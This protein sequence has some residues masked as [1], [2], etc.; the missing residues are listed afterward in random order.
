MK[1]S[2]KVVKSSMP[3]FEEYAEEIRELWDTHW[4]TNNGS[5]H[6]ELEVKMKEFLDV[7]NL[8]L[9][10]NG[11]L[12]LELLINMMDLSG[13][14]IT[15]A[16]TFPSTTH[17]IVRNGLTPVFC[18]I[19]RYDMTIDADKIEELITEKTSAIL[20]VHI[21]GNPCDVEKI[22]KIAEKHNLKVIYDAAQSF[23]VKVG[24]KGIG[25]FG[26]ASM[27]SLHATKSFHT[28]EGGAVTF[29]DDLMKEKLMKLRTFGCIN[30]R[31][32]GRNIVGINAKMNEFQASMGLCNLRHYQAEI[33]K[34]KSIYHYYLDKLSDVKGVRTIGDMP[35]IEK[36][37]TYFPI[38][39]DPDNYGLSRDDLFDSFIK[40]DIHPKK[41]FY[42][43]MTDYDC[44]KDHYGEADIPV[45]RYIADNVLALPMYADLKHDDVDRIHA[46]LIEGGSQSIQQGSERVGREDKL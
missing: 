27:F 5:K 7:K 17:A 18:D 12:A 16:F 40:N 25:T 30:K 23:G 13:E 1:E 46:I 21:F 24:G 8:E 3:P 38:V 2:I 36:N 22:D 39:I 33:E 26:D 9:F 32:G 31:G 20:P 41:Y 11:H 10:V 14:V 4:L 42:P 29:N 35:T 37:Y 43:L 28:I 6:N 34:R 15:T 44:Y 45:S 19:N